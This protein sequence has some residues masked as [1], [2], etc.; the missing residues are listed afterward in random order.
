MSSKYACKAAMG[1]HA[2]SP[3]GCERPSPA[4][5]QPGHGD[6]SSHLLSATL[7]IYPVACEAGEA[8]ERTDG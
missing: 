7:H 4:S 2:K 6:F 1:P 3:R 5:P 8:S